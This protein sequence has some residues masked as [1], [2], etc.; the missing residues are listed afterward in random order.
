MN[1]ASATYDV[2]KRRLSSSGSYHGETSYGDNDVRGVY[3]VSSPYLNKMR[4]LDEQYGIKREG[5]NL[6]I[7][8]AAVIAD[9]KGDITIGG[10]RSRGTRGL[11]E[12]LT[13][14]KSIV[15]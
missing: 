2:S 10:T 9:K 15:T 1:E 14:K 8:S 3:E 5:N 12:L 7:G 4:F 6:M 13:R 11:W